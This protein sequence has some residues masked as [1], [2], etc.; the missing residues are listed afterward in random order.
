M[1]TILIRDLPSAILIGLLLLGVSCKENE[2]VNQA[3]TS[4]EYGKSFFSYAR[5]EAK[6]DSLEKAPK[7]EELKPGAM[8]YSVC[9]NNNI[10]NFVCLKCG[11]ATKYDVWTYDLIQTTRSKL[12][13]IKEL[14]I[15]VIDNG[16]CE[17]C[18]P[19][20]TPK[21]FKIYIKYSDKKDRIASSVNFHEAEVLVQFLK[22][23][24]VFTG[25]QGN[26][27]DMKQYLPLLK[28]ILLGK[29]VK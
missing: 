6:L 5:I 28:K 13:G 22:G 12:N 26:E 11:K 2:G 23:N 14:D 21:T 27:S 19:G 1:N 7:T 9:V 15:K 25:E 8:C 20:T 17:H 18:Y 16:F 24:H 3:F 10:T 29:E 4:T